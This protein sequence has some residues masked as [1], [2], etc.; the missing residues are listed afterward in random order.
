MKL[1]LLFVI[2]LL[3][4][5]LDL[6][7]LLVLLLL[8]LNLVPMLLVRNI[9]WVDLSFL[10]DTPSGGITAFRLGWLPVL[11]L[12]RLPNIL[13]VLLHVLL[14]YLVR[15]YL[16]ALMTLRDSLPVL[17][18]HLVRERVKLPVGPSA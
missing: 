7:L 8:E 3:N 9:R 15:W 16:V 12:V 17:L 6:L 11:R 10:L 18:L 14:V 2:L 13:V 4:L 5:H 1:L